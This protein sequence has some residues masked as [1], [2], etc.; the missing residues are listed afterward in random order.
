MSCRKIK[1]N[2]R[3]PLCSLE[4]N[5]LKHKQTLKCQNRVTKANWMSPPS[6]SPLTKEELTQLWI[7]YYTHGHFRDESSELIENKSKNKS[8]N[9]DKMDNNFTTTENTQSIR[10]VSTNTWNWAQV[11]EVNQSNKSLNEINSV[12]FRNDIGNMNEFAEVFI[13]QKWLNEKNTSNF[14]NIESNGCEFYNNN[15]FIFNSD[16]EIIEPN[17]HKS[18]NTQFNQDCYKENID[19][20]IFSDFKYNN[21][22]Y[23]QY[24]Y[25][26]N[27]NHNIS[28][29]INID[30]TI[31]NNYWYND[32]KNNSALSLE[33]E[34]N[35]FDKLNYTI[36]DYQNELASNDDSL[37]EYFVVIKNN[38]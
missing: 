18:T 38:D 11:T 28:N 2:T 15:D 27:N 14:S 34:C 36:N 19:P 20:N 3:K 30:Q 16:S 35:N 13:N 7:K 25:G 12:N 26:M 31:N 32:T 24:N 8:K 10:I 23:D 37:L 4:T 1:N 29:E 17:Q 6:G 9:E 21:N 5:I 22:Y 33:E